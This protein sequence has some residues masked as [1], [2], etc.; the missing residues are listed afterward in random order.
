MR[1]SCAEWANVGDGMEENFDAKLR[2][3]VEETRE[4]GWSGRH[5]EHYVR[6]L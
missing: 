1:Y 2:S 3:K 6:L 5:L 4:G